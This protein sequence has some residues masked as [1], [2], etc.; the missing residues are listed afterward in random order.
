MM[1]VEMAMSLTSGPGEMVWIMSRP[2]QLDVRARARANVI[3]GQRIPGS[4]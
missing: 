2:K 3:G 4:R 1:D